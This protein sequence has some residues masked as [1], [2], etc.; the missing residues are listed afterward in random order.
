[1]GQF[2]NL[3]WQNRDD[4]VIHADPKGL[5]KAYYIYPPRTENNESDLFELALIHENGFLDDT[6]TTIHGSLEEAKVGAQQHYAGV[7]QLHCL[8]I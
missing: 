7:L 8:N 4:G 1:M 5:L 6:E 3:F 2:K